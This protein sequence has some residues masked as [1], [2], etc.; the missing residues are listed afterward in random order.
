MA[1]AM[2]AAIRNQYRQAFKNVY[3]NN[4]VNPIPTGVKNAI[5][6]H[7][8]GT[9]YGSAAGMAL[10]GYQGAT[11]PNS[12]MFTGAIWGGLTGGIKGG[13]AGF[14]GSMGWRYGRSVLSGSRGRLNRMRQLGNRT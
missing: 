9:V 2:S 12:G 8:P 5:I 4:A 1:W 10:G 13:L 7:S 11:D 6:R 3:S 14:G